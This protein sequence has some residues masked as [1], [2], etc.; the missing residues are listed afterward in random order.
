MGLF[1]RGPNR[2]E[3]LLADHDA[4]EKKRIVAEARGPMPVQPIKAGALIATRTG[5]VAHIKS[6]LYPGA[7]C[8]AMGQWQDWR[9]VG[10]DEGLRD[11][12]RCGMAVE[13]RA[14]S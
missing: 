4:A 3:Q 6:A 2:L 8:E 11:C 12:H 14:A 13:R 10:S 5:Q 1:R 9:I 7:R